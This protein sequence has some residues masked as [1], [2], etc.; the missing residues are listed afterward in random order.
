[1]EELYHA[2]AKNNPAIKK[3]I[4]H[5]AKCIIVNAADKE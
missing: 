4:I 1:M 2:A 3:I 5:N